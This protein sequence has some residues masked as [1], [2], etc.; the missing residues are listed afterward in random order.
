[1]EQ[2]EQAPIIIVRKRKKTRHHGHSSGWKTAFADF[3]TAMMAF[4][5]VLWLVDATSVE[6]KQAEAAKPGPATPTL[7]LSLSTEH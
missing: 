1:M 2:A 6:E 7:T 5:L 4:F 3:A